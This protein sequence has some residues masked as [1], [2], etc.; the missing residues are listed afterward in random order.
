[1]PIADPRLRRTERSLEA[2]EIPSATKDLNYLPVL[3]SYEEVS[4]GHFVA[5]E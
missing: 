3:V 1:V 5:Q 2:D 4:N